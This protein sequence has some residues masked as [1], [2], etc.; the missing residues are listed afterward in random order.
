MKV[1][2]SSD[3]RHFSIVG[4]GSCG[5]TMLSEAMLVS[6]GVI[7]RLGSIEKGSTG[8]DY[9][10]DEHKRQISI[11]T[12]PLFVPSLVAAASTPMNLV[13]TRKCKKLLPLAIKLRK[14]SPQNL[15]AQAIPKV[16][17]ISSYTF[18]TNHS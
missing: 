7:N 4:H 6:A 17:E 16:I 14:S 11:A 15:L 18:T 5:K 9:S 13:T 2:N 8:S 10:P 3:I 12:L 1:Y